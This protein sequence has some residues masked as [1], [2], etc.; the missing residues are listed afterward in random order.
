VRFGTLVRLLLGCAGLLL[1][2]MAGPPAVAPAEAQSRAAITR[3]DGPPAPP[4]R[5]RRAPQAEQAQPAAEEQPE[6]TLEEAERLA[7]PGRIGDVRD[8]APP[9]EPDAEG[10]EPALAEADATLPQLP[11][12]DGDLAAPPEPAAP[13]DGELAEEPAPVSVDG[14]LSRI[15]QLGLEQGAEL[16]GGDPSFRR[17]LPERRFGPWQPLGARLG[18]MIVLPQ[19]EAARFHTDNLFRSPTNRR[20][21]QAIELRPSLRLRSNWARHEIEATVLGGLTWY[22]EFSSENER[23]IAAQARGRLDLRRFTTLTG[24]LG[25]SYELQQRGT[26]ESVAGQE[27]PAVIVRNA[28]AILDQRINRVRL[29]LRGSRTDYDYSTITGSD[30]A[31]GATIVSGPDRNYAQDIVGARAGYE[32]SSAMT[33]FADIA[34]DRRRHEAANRADN[35]LRDSDGARVRAGVVLD[36]RG[37]LQGQLSIGHATQRPRD[38]RLAE[39]SGFIVDAGLAWQPTALTELRL[40]ARSDVTETTL[41]RSGGALAR[42]VEGELRHALRRNLILIAGLSYSVS[43]YAGIELTEAETRG[44]LGVEYYIAR[45]ALLTAA[46]QHTHFDSSEAR[47]DWDESRVRV[48]V[49]LRR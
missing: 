32:L 7:D 25:Y 1:A 20:S 15:D 46:W 33:F 3:P 26:A 35:I 19:V 44:R 47:R 5:A 24:E 30:G 45:E 4:Q 40:I 31:G 29:Q 16:V 36:V 22:D 2:A 34:G 37:R 27:R 21:D 42:A 23:R 14:A 6:P 17:V 28:G 10:E 38:G 13:R 43:D 49:N 12:R 39:V 18:S 9:T 8:A 48:G 41:A 11:P